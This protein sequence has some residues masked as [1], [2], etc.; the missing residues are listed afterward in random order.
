[1]MKAEIF[2][3]ENKLGSARIR[4]YR[5]LYQKIASGD[6]PP[7]STISELILAK[8]L[9]ISR[10][11]I[12]EAIGRLTAEGLIEQSPHRKAVVAQFNRRDII[13][14]YELRK[15]LEMYAV[16]KAARQPVRDSARKELES[17]N[18]SIRLMKD[19]LA[20]SGAQTLNEEMMSHFAGYD[21]G[22]HTLL[23]RLANNGRILK[24]ANDTHILLRIFTM[25]YKEHDVR[26]LENICLLHEAILQ[27]V[28]EQDSEKARDLVREHIEGSLEERLQVYDQL[29][30]EASVRNNV[31]FFFGL[32]P[33]IEFE[34]GPP[35]TENGDGPPKA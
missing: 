2:G 24:V 6:L 3:T 20:A 9:A 13:E 19:R 29:E 27:A 14:L 35:E 18:S 15:V 4:A 16:E 32:K 10:T 33:S 11:P 23:V 12:R 31:R 17:L 7:G 26:L 21:L 25:Q 28:V 34:T 30:I 5:Y 1:M 8:E 22:F